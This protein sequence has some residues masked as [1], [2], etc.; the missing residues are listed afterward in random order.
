M[1]AMTL[2]LVVVAAATAAFTLTAK[3]VGRCEVL[4]RQNH[5]I[6]DSYLASVEEADFWWSVD[7]P[8]D[9]AQ[10]PY[11]SGG[12]GNVF[13]PVDL[14]DAYWNWNVADPQTWQRSGEY[15][16]MIVGNVEHPDFSLV[17]SVGDADPIRAWSHQL[18]DTMA[19][20][21]GTYGM[22]DYLPPCADWWLVHG[23]PAVGPPYQYRHGNFSAVFY[24]RCNTPI[25]SI[26]H[27]NG[28]R[29]LWTLHSFLGVSPR[30]GWAMRYD[31]TRT[32]SLANLF[33][34]KPLA[35]YVWATPDILWDSATVKSELAAVPPHLRLRPPGWPSVRGG[36][37]RVENAAGR[38]PVIDLT[39]VD[40]VSGERISFNSLLVGTSL[41]GAR[42][43]RDWP[44]WNPSTP[45]LDQ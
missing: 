4:S 41:R 12:N 6:R 8:F 18:I 25:T 28:G 42:Q 24:D 38:S 33:A 37:L 36:L 13:K 20:N 9:A 1:V 16:D 22:A 26:R 44:H 11:R 30:D 2:S 34:L 7:D 31:A 35:D 19:T 32:P 40:D 14:P 15:R 27:L 3:V 5:A 10:R 29:A 23:Q 17:G 21:L 43:Q 39:I 45:K